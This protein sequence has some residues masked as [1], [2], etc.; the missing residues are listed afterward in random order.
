[1]PARDV[2]RFR[3]GKR[4]REYYS[5]WAQ[6]YI[7]LSVGLSCRRRHVLRSRLG[8][9]VSL[10][11]LPIKSALV[12]THVCCLL[13]DRRGAALFLSCTWRFRAKL[14]PRWKSLWF[15]IYTP[16]KYYKYDPNTRTQVITGLS[17]S[18]KAVPYQ[19]VV[20]VVVVVVVHRLH[21]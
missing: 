14:V 9:F 5:T 16:P 1:M 18:F 3:A 20:L 8:R 7:T 11:G 15:S 17:A 10:T 4:Q 19:V 6:K 12:G 13:R 21:R 2:F